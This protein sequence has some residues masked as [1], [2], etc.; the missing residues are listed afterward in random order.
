[1]ERRLH[2]RRHVLG[3][4]PQLEPVATAAAAAA[5]AANLCGRQV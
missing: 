3:E 4:L 1:M 2:F 5:T